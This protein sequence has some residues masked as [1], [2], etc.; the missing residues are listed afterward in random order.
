MMRYLEEQK[1]G[2]DTGTAKIPIVLS[3]II[4]DLSV[5]RD[6]VRPDATMGYSRPLRLLLPHLQRGTSV[7]GWAGRLVKSAG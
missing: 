1:I 6:N 4:Y 7:P 2:F 3:A 5:G